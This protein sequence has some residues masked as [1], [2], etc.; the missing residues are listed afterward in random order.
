MCK[1]H[2]TKGVSRCCGVLSG[3]PVHRKKKS[4]AKLKKNPGKISFRQF[5]ISLSSGQRGAGLFVR[6][7][8]VL[9]KEVQNQVDPGLSS[10]TT[11]S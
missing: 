10:G 2:Q 11:R 9:W 8:A 4:K 1:A 5:G 6:C 3:A 7:L